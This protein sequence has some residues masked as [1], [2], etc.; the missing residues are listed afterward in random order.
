MRM[1]NIKINNKLYQV[2]EGISILDAAKKNDINI[3]TL[4]Y[5]KDIST[6]ASCRVCLVELKNS[7][8]LVTAC[9]FPVREGIEIYT[10]SSKAIQA[11]KKSVELLI[12]NHNK[13]C[14]SCIR[15]NKCELQ[16]LCQELNIREN[17][18]DGE[19]SKQHLDNFANGIIRDTSKCILCQ[20]CIETCKKVQGLGILGLENRGFNTIVSPI[21]NMSFKDVNCMQCGQCVINCPTSALSEKENLELVIEALNNPNLHVV[22]QTAPAI[23]AS[24]GEEFNMPI[25]TRVTNKMVSALKRI[26]FDRVYDTN[27]GAD[28]TIMEE[29]YEFIERVKNN[30]ILPMLT[31]CSPGWINYL[32]SEYPEL[33]KHVSTCKSPHMMLGAVLKTYYAKE[34]NIDPKNIFVVS[35]MPCTAKKD[36]IKRIENKKTEY[37]DVDVVLT[38]RECAK[39]IKM[40]GIDLNNIDESDFDNDMFGEYSGAGVIFG[41]S[42][43]VMEAALR[44]VKEKLENKSLQKIEFN[45]V[46]GLT[47]IKAATIDINEKKYNIAV[48]SGML[49]AKILLDDIKNNKSKYHF[50]EI[51]GCPGGCI[52]GGGQPFISSRIRN[53]ENDYCLKRANALY[54]E[55][56]I[57]KVRKSHENPQIINLYKNFL[58]YEGSDI[59]HK[60]LHTS[61]DKKEK[62]NL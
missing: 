19:Y 54:D 28:L 51:M 59:C 15:N 10:H 2:E 58:K 46:R 44:T 45:E 26:G 53:Y 27:F 16:N 39:L 23:R 49:N 38:T 14:L 30:G 55:D 48:V 62:Y 8:T 6:T 50:I 4:C 36:E 40:Y 57:K 43:G 20:R 11:R 1:V 29:G 32:E 13:N 3:P 41:V 9:N 42:G 31:S 18:Y 37:F 60:I 21:F 61:F 34:K 47:G 12:S 25:G 7:K 22:V 33:I 17:I 52:N 35:I 24:L 56:I 5:L